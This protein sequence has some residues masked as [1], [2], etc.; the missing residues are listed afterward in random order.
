MRRVLLLVAV[1]A[2][3]CVPEAGAW[4]WPTDG[5]VLQSFVFDPV[6]PYAAGEHRGI[7]VAGPAGAAVLA[8]RAGTITFAGT[9]P[10]SGASLTILTD[11]GYSVTLT[12]LGSLAVARGAAV[13]EGTVVAHLAATG[14]A[15]HAQPYVHLGVRVAAQAQGY[16]DPAALLPPRGVTPPAPV[17]PPATPPVVAVTA[18]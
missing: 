12:H 8:P 18:A 17:P 5:V 10:G 11:D 9:V 16:V 1:A 13:D 4:T 7:D 3:I 15:A 14:D 6:H 2:M